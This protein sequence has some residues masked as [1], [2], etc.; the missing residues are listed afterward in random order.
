MNDIGTE[1]A[2]FSFLF[3]SHQSGKLINLYANGRPLG[4]IEDGVFIAE[5][6]TFASDGKIT[7]I[8]VTA[9]P[10]PFPFTNLTS[11]KFALHSAIDKIE[12]GE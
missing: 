4:R 9:L 5:G 11:F 12:L 7:P 10:Q 1:S 3:A 2:Y 8:R 6:N